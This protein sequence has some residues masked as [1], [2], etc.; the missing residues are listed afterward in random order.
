[1]KKNN[2]KMTIKEYAKKR[3]IEGL[4]YERMFAGENPNM[5]MQ[6][7]YKRMGLP[8]CCQNF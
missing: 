4:E 2:K 1:M 7:Y 5:A 8:K 6:T 3:G